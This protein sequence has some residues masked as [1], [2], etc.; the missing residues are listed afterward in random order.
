VPISV[1][2][3]NDWGEDNMHWDGYTIFSLLS[4]IALLLCSMFGRE[5]GAKDR[6][7]LAGGGVAFAA[8]GIYVAN[9]TSGTFVFP[10]WIFVIPFG[11]LFYTLVVPALKASAGAGQSAKGSPSETE[12]LPRPA[13]GR[14]SPPPPPGNAA[15]P[16]PEQDWDRPDRA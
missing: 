6:A 15:G 16:T 12:T 8:Y 1:E 7:W 5:I 11:A 10:I 3:W 2:A 4:G 14:T 9:Q 13:A